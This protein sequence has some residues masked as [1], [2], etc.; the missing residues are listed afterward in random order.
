MYRKPSFQVAYMACRK[1]GGNSEILMP[2][3]SVAFVS[4]VVTKNCFLPQQWLK[5]TYGKGPL[6]NVF[7]STKR[8]VPS[9]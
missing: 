6:A 7:V 1:F 9:S 2:A 8:R 3:S 4:R 5:E